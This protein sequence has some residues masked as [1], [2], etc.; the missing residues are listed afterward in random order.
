MK[1]AKFT[2]SIYLAISFF[3]SDL[4]AQKYN[5]TFI[6][7]AQKSLKNFGYDPGQ[8]DGIFGEKTRS[9]VI[10][11]QRERH[12][13][14]TGNLDQ[15][16]TIHLSITD[17]ATQLKKLIYC[18]PDWPTLILNTQDFAPYHYP[19]SRLNGMVSGPVAEVIGR[20]CQEA[21]LN[22]FIKINPVWEEAQQE[23]RDGK[24]DGL[25]VIAWNSKREEYLR[26]SSPIATAEYG[27]FVDRRNTV[28]QKERINPSDFNGYIVGVYGPSGTSKSL[29]EIQEELKNKGMGLT[30]K[31]YP[32]DKPAFQDLAQGA[33][34]AVYSNKTTG[35]II[36]TAGNLNLLY[37]GT[38]KKIT[39]YI[40]FSK[41]NVPQNIVDRFNN[42]HQKL[43]DQNIIQETFSNYGL[44]TLEQ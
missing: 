2:I 22:C 11:F 30:I 15:V 44:D 41:Q 43:Y 29:D 21:Q 14:T 27:F 12:L 9:E 38:H 34:Q 16:T 36:I 19:D 35:K 28:G 13:E 42:A 7:Q 25:F 18:K 39:Y 3:T 1:N 8:I 24:A 40:G 6:T 20:T 32:D 4:N 31:T 23:V 5:V 10:R 17:C 33:I 37:A 26:R